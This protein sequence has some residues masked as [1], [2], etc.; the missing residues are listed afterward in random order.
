MNQPLPKRGDVN[1]PLAVLIVE[2]SETDALL[3][4]RLLRK[5]G[6]EVAFERVETAEEMHSA[7]EKRNWDIIISDYNLPQFSGPAALELLKSRKED[8][9]FIVVSGVIGEESAVALMKAGAHDYLLKENLVRLVPAV[10]RELDQAMIRRGRKQSEE[11]L[12]ASEEKYRMLVE[13]ASDA[14]FVADFNGQCLDVNAAGCKLL[15]Y[16]REE[17]QNLRVNDFAKFSLNGPTK[18]NEFQKGRTLIIEGEV[19]HKDGTLIFVEISARQLPD[20]NFQGIVRDVTERKRAEEKLRQLSSAVEHS[21]SAIVITDANGCIEYINPKFTALTGYTFEEVRGKTPPNTY[22]SSDLQTEAVR[23]EHWQTV[24]DGKEWRG[25]MLNRK[26]NGEP[27]WE[28]VSISPI[29][30]S[31]GLITH[32]VAVSEDITL[33]KE[34]EEK[35]QRLNAGLE[36]LAMTDYLTSLYN[37]RYFMQRGAE[38]FKRVGRTNQPLSLLMLDI[39]QFKKVNDTHGHEAGDMALQQVAATLKSSLRETDILGRIGGE[40]FAVLLPNT[41]L[42]EAAILAERVC[43]SVG[44]LGIKIPAAILTITISIG[45][46]M[47]KS[48]MQDIDDMLKHADS[49]MYKAKRLGGNRVMQYE[50]GTETDQPPVIAGKQYGNFR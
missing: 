3:I 37:R 32:F 14:I 42:K 19:L 4:I 33:R 43:R 9:P 15:G 30:N 20:G 8:L 48:P 49:A 5:A 11:A 25:E 45:V 50:D 44:N 26:K 18:T 7:L 31:T 24:R 40:E 28:A 21:P 39:D 17:I 35:I 47:L 41:P 10:Q 6:Y 29:M 36:Q 34:N 22:G 23:R 13:Q 12:R 2:D 16:T 1:F 27:Y 46:V 38:E